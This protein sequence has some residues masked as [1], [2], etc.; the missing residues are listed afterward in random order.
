MPRSTCM[1]RLRSSRT[2]EVATYKPLPLSPM[3]A[4]GAPRLAPCRAAPFN[5]LPLSRMVA[6]LRSESVRA[7]VSDA[8][9]PPLHPAST[10]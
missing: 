8:D 3:V 5:S 2:A 1:V 4:S 6:R 10:E 9:P 7:H